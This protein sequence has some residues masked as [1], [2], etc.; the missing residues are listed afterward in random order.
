MEASSKPESDASACRGSKEAQA[1]SHYVKGSNGV[2][3]KSEPTGQVPG[4]AWQGEQE[5]A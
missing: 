5:L 2:T 3:D 4:L 1:F